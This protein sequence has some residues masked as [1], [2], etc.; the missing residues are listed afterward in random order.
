MPFAIPASFFGQ[1]D[2]CA[3]VIFVQRVRFSFQTLSFAFA[4]AAFPEILRAARPPGLFFFQLFRGFLEINHR[5]FI[6]PGSGPLLALNA[7]RAPHIILGFLR[8]GPFPNLLGR[9]RRL[10]I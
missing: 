7:A 6:L 10:S 1:A 3:F 4:L 9:K 8:H 5:T 2:S